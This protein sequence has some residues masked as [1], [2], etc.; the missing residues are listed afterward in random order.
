MGKKREAPANPAAAAEPAAAPAAA[1]GRGGAG[2]GQ[3]RKRTKATPA[4]KPAA[5]NPAEGTRG[6]RGVDSSLA[7]HPSALLPSAELACPTH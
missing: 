2:R 1:R 5:A 4:P 7:R 6:L 3:G